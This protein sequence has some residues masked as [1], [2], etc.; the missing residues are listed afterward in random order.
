MLS[1]NRNKMERYDIGWDLDGN[2]SFN[3]EG[4]KQVTLEREYRAEAY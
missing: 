4:S 3:I 2:N 1:D